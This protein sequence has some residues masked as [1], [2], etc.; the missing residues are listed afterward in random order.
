MFF[1]SRASRKLSPKRLNDSTVNTIANAGTHTSQGCRITIEAFVD[2]DSILPH[3]GSGGWMPNPT[4]LKTAS[5][6]INRG[7]SR[8]A[9]IIINVMVCGKT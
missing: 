1:G 3:E 8:V 2:T 9:E 6:T 4:R 7:I 5:T